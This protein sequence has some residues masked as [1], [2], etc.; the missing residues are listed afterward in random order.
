MK[1]AVS[2]L[3]HGLRAAIRFWLPGLLILA[4]APPALSESGPIGHWKLDDAPQSPLI[5][6]ASPG[7][8]HGSLTAAATGHSVD[9]KTGRAVRFPAAGSIR[10]DKHAA[11]LGKLT[12]FTVSMWIQYDGG[13]SRQLFTFSD[14]TLNHRVQMEVH[15]GALGFGW[16]DGGTFQ[17]TITKPLAWEPGRWYHV[18][19]VNDSKAGKSILRS[20]DLVRRTHANTLSPAGL[21]SP[22]TSVEIG[23]LNG[24]YPYSGCIDEVRLFD[25]ALPLDEQLALYDA[26]NN[27]PVDPKWTEA[28]TA[29]IEKQRRLAM[30]RRA[31]ELFFTEEA[32]RL[33]K[34]ELHQKAEWL[35]QTEDD[36]LLTRA[37][38]EIVWTRQMIDRLQQRA[39][40]PDLADEAAALKQLERRVSADEAS[41]D[42][43][44]TRRLY[45]DVR[46][47]KRRV[48]LKSPEVDFAGIICVDAPYTNRSLDTHGTFQQT[49]WVHESRFR[50]EMCASHGA[51]L[52]VLEDFAK[53]PAP[54]QLAPICKEGARDFGQP[55]A[56]LSFDLSF[57]SE[58]ALFCMKP[59]DEKA[60]HLYEIGLDGNGFRQIT[61]GGYSDIDPIYLPGNRYLF[62]STRAE[63][64][65][66]C[67]MWARSYIQT[68][69]DADGKNIHILTPGT[70]P[71]FSPSLLDDG[72]IIS[73][74]WEY[75]DKSPMHIQSLWTM[76]PDG[77]GAA[78][79]WGNQSVYPDHLG[80][81]RQIP[82]TSKVMFNGFG[83]HD[84]WVGCIGVVDPKR[85]L[86]FPDGIW[87][88]TQEMHWP[89]VGD[90]AIRTPLLT[91]EYHTSGKYAAYKTP[92]PLSEELFLVSARTGGIWVGGMRSGHDPTIGKFKL[93]LMDIYGNRELIYQ[94]ENNV[95][96][97]QPVRARKS[98]PSLPDLADMPGSEKDNP[99]IRPGV[100]ASNNIFESAPSEIRRYGKYLRVVEAMPKS[101]SVGIV[102]SGGKPFGSEGPNTAWGVWGEK[103]LQGKT[104]TPTTDLSWGDASV[105]QGP[106]TSVTGPLS[107]KQIHG[108]VPIHEDGSVNFT[109]PPCRML[110]FQVLDEHYRAVHTMRSWVSARP[111]EYRGCVGCHEAHNSTPVIRS[112]KVATASDT[113]QPPPWGVHS[114]SF[115]SDVQPI[116]DRAC[117]ECHQ[118]NGQAVET[119]DLTLRPDEVGEKRWGG[120][121][122]EPYLTL[123]LGKNHHHLNGT[124]GIAAANTYVGLP[125]TMHVPYDTLPPLTY[126]S[127]K[128]KLIAEAMDKKRCGKSISPKDLRM[129]I[130]W[131]DLWAMYRS[132]EDVRDIEDAPS[133]WFPLWTY[134]P[135]TKT[136]PRVRTEYCQD[137]YTCPEDRR[138]TK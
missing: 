45:F 126:L 14:G 3:R 18:V 27:E 61:F 52:L 118:G 63:V 89:E 16:Q 83:H 50:S 101:Y 75:V 91:D 107:V 46:A 47:L 39:D 137:E 95:L 135:K 88:V 21:R 80:E 56:M 22:V 67:G 111:G 9:G 62:L 128:S 58:K 17:N 8:L 108:I 92:Y 5:A 57:D 71:E 54:R 40:A 19:F 49:E 65:A 105:V 123:T 32:P 94:G 2:T 130:A 41:I 44:E 132:D 114:L 24:A 96:Y 37:D 38:K 131:V 72:R 121:F 28:K 103:F 115:V 127:P 81:A 69:C 112:V 73:T 20:N 77:T 117:A 82:G 74:R 113:I 116:F 109:V 129:L 42:P 124:P 106:V 34:S 53:T 79:Y 97:A 102:H 23:S 84:V 51:K 7:A 133:E 70:E 86:N 90:G 93:Y 104:P 1:P 136:A 66:Q 26:L 64:Y 85:G 110:Y 59:E 30:A 60:Y 31:R 78:A 55:G 87:K 11:K 25:S 35:F 98:P 10:L 122:P 138:S 76:R 48:M 4:L 99:T 33:S 36:D 120:I 134:P 43:S 125:S 6:D 12:D 119:L 15:N 100:F 13:A 68:R 29:L